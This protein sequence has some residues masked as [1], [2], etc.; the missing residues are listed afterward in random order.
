M[1]KFQ[2]QAAISCELSVIRARNADLIP[3]GS[4]FFVRCYMSAGN[5]NRVRFQSREVS[6]SNMVW[7][8]SFSLDCFGTKESMRSMLLEGTVIFEL[9]CRSGISFFGRTRKSQLLGKAEV[10][11]KTVLESSTMDVEKWVVMET[12]KRLPDGVKPPAVQIG[13]KVDG[14]VIPVA[15]K[16]VKQ[17]KSCGD[18]CQCK[19]C[20]NCEL[21][22]LDGALEFSC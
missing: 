12:G 6:S 18:G 15:T 3:T 20:L 16:A 21:F 8:Q 9:R 17:R 7:N 5:K 1:D 4:S 10:P 19:S 14:A 2:D 11:W 22:A 13:M